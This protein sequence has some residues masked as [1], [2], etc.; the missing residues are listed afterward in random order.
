MERRSPTSKVD[1]NSE[2]CEFTNRKKTG[3][4]NSFMR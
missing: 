1:N 3:P 2:I 4:M